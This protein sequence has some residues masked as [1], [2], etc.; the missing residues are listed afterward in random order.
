[1]PQQHYQ[2]VKLSRRINTHIEITTNTPYR[3]VHSIN[4]CA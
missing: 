2:Q 3:Y 1:M 4:T